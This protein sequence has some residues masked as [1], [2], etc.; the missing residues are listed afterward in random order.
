MSLSLRQRRTTRNR[1][2]LASEGA[3]RP[4]CGAD[5][6]SGGAP[7]GT[8]RVGAGGLGVG[9]WIAVGEPVESGP[10]PFGQ[11]A[12]VGQRGIERPAHLRVDHR[13]PEEPDD[14]WTPDP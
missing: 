12:D 5:A 13:P 6:S 8:C 11:L 10:D 9:G 14:L 7:D 2:P 3:G 1:S 4:F